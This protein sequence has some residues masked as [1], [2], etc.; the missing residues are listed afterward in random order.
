MLSKCEEEAK[1]FQSLSSSAAVMHKPT[2]SKSANDASLFL[3]GKPAIE[4]SCIGDIWH[5]LSSIPRRLSST[6]VMATTTR[7]ITH[8]HQS[9]Y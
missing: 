8:R 6:G 5:C 7:P 9:C 4:F 1:L 3:W 2:E